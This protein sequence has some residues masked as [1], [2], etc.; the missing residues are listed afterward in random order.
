MFRD[1]IFDVVTDCTPEK[2][3]HVL[4]TA[5]RR[6]L[7]GIGNARLRATTRMTDTLPAPVGPRNLLG[8]RC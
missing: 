1:G 7:H 5:R 8:L 6:W 4:R 2:L 3:E